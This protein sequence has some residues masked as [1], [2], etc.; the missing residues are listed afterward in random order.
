MAGNLIQPRVRVSWAGINLS[1]Y[2]GPGDFPKETPAVYDVEVQLQSQ[3]QAPTASMK[4]DPTGPGFSLY[5]SFIS[6]PEYMKSRIF[7]DFFYAGGKRIRMAFV[8][9]GQS[10]SYGND[11]TVT[12]KMKTELDGLIN[13][14][15]RSNGQAH[16]EKKGESYL[17]A[18]KKLQTQ[19][20]IQEN[21][22]RYEPKAKTSMEKA[23][24]QSA[25]GNDQTYGAAVANVVQQNGNTVF[26]NNI[27]EPNL[28]VF[29]PF[30][31]KPE[32][33]TVLNG[34]TELPPGTDPKPD[35]RY[36]Y[37]VGPSIIDSLVRETEWKPP[38]QTKQNNPSTQAKA[39]NSKTAR[40]TQQK[41]ATSAQVRLT[42][43]TRPGSSPQG[44]ANARA[45]PGISNVYNPDG[46][47]KQNFLEDERTASMTFQT[48]LCP[49]LVGIKPYDVVYI[50]SFG[51]IDPETKKYVY[52][53]EDW[54]VESVSYDQNDGNVSISVQGTREYGLGAAMDKKNA[55]KF[56][57]YAIEQGLIGPNAT[58]DNWD[59]YAWVTPLSSK[60]P[61]DT[62]SNGEYNPTA[63]AQYRASG[64]S[65]N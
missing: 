53:T 9:S 48:M 41:P 38:Q 44:T 11:M 14:N 46:P 5:E 6:N 52:F 39:R 24:I 32:Q 40:S 33:N 22:L 35:Q 1:S 12:V 19:Y 49:A 3:T 47:T 4:W 54:I 31:W 61:Q 29:A 36:G 25:Y 59:K 43:S 27:G 18:L 64:D 42:N 15:I 8:W 10:I 28:V 2:D 26:A 37:I 21:L 23:T 65:F 50:P 55:D 62:L 7:I 58:L 17:N 60:S 16:D 13:G 30:S 34:V 51:K 20:G 56:E 57:K 45:N 63:A